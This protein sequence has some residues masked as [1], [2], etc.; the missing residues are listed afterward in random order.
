MG[1][2]RYF[3]FLPLKYVHFFYAL[4][5][6]NLT[7]SIGRKYKNHFLLLSF[8]SLFDAQNGVPNQH[9][10]MLILQKSLKVMEKNISGL[11]FKVA[12]A[13]DLN[14]ILALMIK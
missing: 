5:H 3:H 11:L 14:I 6:A 1:S 7:N 13:L 9:N 12:D 8:L 2:K 4:R 10:F